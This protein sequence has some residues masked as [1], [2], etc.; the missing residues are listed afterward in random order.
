MINEYNLIWS[1]PHYSFIQFFSY[2]FLLFYFSTNFSGN[3]AKLEVSGLF[4]YFLLY[5]KKWVVAYIMYIIL[6]WI[7]SYW[8][9]VLEEKKH[10]FSCFVE[11]LVSL[12][13]TM[14]RENP[15]LFFFSSCFLINLHFLRIQTQNRYWVSCFALYDHWPLFYFFVMVNIIFLFLDLLLWVLFIQLTL[16]SLLSQLSI[17]LRSPKCVSLTQGSRQ[18][19]NWA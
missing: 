15:I 19:Q 4:L 13:N 10:M 12:F 1:H 8:V 16:H 18:L 5:L 17:F 9:H 11:S 2:L 6:Y 7:W 14:P 3:S